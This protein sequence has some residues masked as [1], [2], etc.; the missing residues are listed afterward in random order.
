MTLKIYNVLGQNVATLTDRFYAA[1]EYSINWN[2]DNQASGIYY[3]R[4][5]TGSETLVRSMALLK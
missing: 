4:L 2:A 1:G 3:Y 5:K